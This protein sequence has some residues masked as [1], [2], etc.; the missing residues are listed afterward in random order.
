M[1]IYL[2]VETLK[3]RLEVMKSFIKITLDDDKISKKALKM[4]LQLIMNELD[5]ISVSP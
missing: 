4:T 1:K 2:D 5:E 3:R